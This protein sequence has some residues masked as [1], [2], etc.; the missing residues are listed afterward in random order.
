MGDTKRLEALQA[1]ALAA[2]SASGGPIFQEL[3]RYLAEILR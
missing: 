3:A 1:A 2:S